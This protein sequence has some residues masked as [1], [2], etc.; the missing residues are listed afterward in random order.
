MWVPDSQFLA[1]PPEYRASYRGPGKGG[2][3][4]F[5]FRVISRNFV[6]VI[7][8]EIGAYLLLDFSWLIHFP[9]LRN[10]RFRF[11]KLCA[12][13]RNCANVPKSNKIQVFA[14]FRK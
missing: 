9:T 5:T 14:R 8:L 13:K 12:S 1:F 3:E 2:H 11:V 6:K 4:I 7:S 10:F